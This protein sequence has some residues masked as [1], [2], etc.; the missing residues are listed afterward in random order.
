MIFP[1]GAYQHPY[2]LWVLIWLTPVTLLDS[3]CQPL[4]ITANLCRFTFKKSV[5]FE[6]AVMK[7]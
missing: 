2:Y 5:T 3:T 6:L 1:L 7:L 4:K